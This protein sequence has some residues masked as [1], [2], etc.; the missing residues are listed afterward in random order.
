MTMLIIIQATIVSVSAAVELEEDFEIESFSEEN[1]YENELL[2]DGEN[3]SL[4]SAEVEPVII[5][6]ETSNENEEP[7]GFENQS[8][9][10]DIADEEVLESFKA[11]NIV[12]TKG[13]L[14]DE[15]TN[16]SDIDVELVGAAQNIEIVY[17][18]C[19]F[20]YLY[21]PSHPN[22]NITS[23]DD[24]IVKCYYKTYSNGSTQLYLLGMKA[25]YSTIVHVTDASTGAWIESFVCKVVSQTG[26]IRTCVGQKSSNYVFFSY[27]N[28]SNLYVGYSESIVAYDNIEYSTGYGQDG[29]LTNIGVYLNKY[30]YSVNV[31]PYTSGTYTMYVVDQGS[32]VATFDLI[33]QEHEWNSGEI[34]TVP[35][36]YS[37]G[38]KTYTCT[39]CGATKTETI[40]PIAHQWNS[41]STVDSMPSC[42]ESGSKSIHC[43]V[44]N[45]IKNGSEE[46]IPAYGHS[47]DSGTITRTQTC[48]EEGIMTYK[49]SRCGSSR[50][51][52]IPMI[53][54]IWEKEKTIDIE[55]TCELTG[56]KSIHCSVCNTIKE[57]SQEEIPMIDHTETIDNEVPPTCTEPGLTEG[58]H[59]IIC[60]QV[61][62]PQDEIPVNGHTEVVDEAVNATCTEPGLTEGR[63]C[64]VCGEVLVPQEEI[65]APGHEIVIDEAVEPTCTETGLTEGSHCSV[66]NE[67]IEEQR[68]IPKLGHTVVVD[69]KVEP[70]CTATGLTK[71]S[72]CS[73]CGEVFVEQEVIP[74]K[75][76][77][78]VANKAVPATC[79]EPGLTEGSHCSECNEIIKEQEIIPAK[80][81]KWGEWKTIKEA[82]A[83]EA[84]LEERQCENCDKKEQREN[85]KLDATI[86]LSKT[87]IT[88]LQGET[89]RISVS[90]L[91]AW[92]EV[93]AWASNDLTVATV[94]SAGEITAAKPGKTTVTVT[95]KSGLTADV[96]VTVQ[97][98]LFSDVTDSAQF[99][100]D[101]IYWAVDNGIATGYSDNTFRPNN[102][103]HRAAVVTFLWRLAGKPDEGITSAFSDMTGNDDFDRAITW[104]ANHGIT[105]GYDDGTFR[106]YQACHRAAIVTFIWRYAGKP[107]TSAAVGFSDLTKNVEFDKAI[108]WAAE[109]NITTGYN[110]G[111]FRPYNSCLRLAVVTFLYRYAHL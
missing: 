54:H 78:E 85:P 35:T 104:A 97:R 87:E 39:A 98:K 92:D 60:G 4:E 23:V 9:E 56:S 93:A 49:C 110:D 19:E 76:H 20:K 26:T 73:V 99:Y 1:N 65:P 50:Y 47:W 111:T 44:C 64:E 8:F 108:A 107:D 11:E 2:A 14:E 18:S 72:H 82:T 45:T 91:A 88:L 80:G 58:S 28:L 32:A 48:T 67:I 15:D 63:H 3:F 52:N 105:T 30:L 75:A 69:K 24:S 62:V 103:C 40:A 42:E 100:F 109:N 90:N 70:T 101:P 89:E 29:S 59:C 68:S 94:T 36:C 53:P 83:K 41:Q 37:S 81:H 43:S 21:Y 102:L 66:C 51:A 95:L 86:T 16:S 96:K 13:L 17:G 5:E 27:T 79:T 106:P 57:G 55:P 33:V 77:T 22:V 46:I 25:G 31:T 74:T 7:V 71:G 61:I 34:T 38:I 10:E 84:G 12:S 6:G